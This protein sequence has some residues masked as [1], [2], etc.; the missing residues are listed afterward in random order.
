MI[1]DFVLLPLNLKLTHSNIEEA[2]VLGEIA[3]FFNQVFVRSEL[4]LQIIFK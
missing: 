1:V 3:Q 2:I 4:I